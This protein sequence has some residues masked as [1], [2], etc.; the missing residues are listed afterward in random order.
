[1]AYWKS[2]S[3]KTQYPTHFITTQQSKTLTQGWATYE[4]VRYRSACVC[5]IVCLS[6]YLSAGGGVKSHFKEKF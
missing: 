6:V 3:F 2:G 5:Q 1:M 4:L